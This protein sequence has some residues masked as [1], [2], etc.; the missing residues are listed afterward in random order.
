MPT[1]RAFLIP[2]VG[3]LLASGIA[4]VDSRPTWDDT[5]VTAGALFVVAALLGAVQPRGFWFTGLVVGIPVLVAN[6]VLHSNYGAAIAVIIGV[7]GAGVGALIGKG[8]GRGGEGR[9]GA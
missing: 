6:V 3:F 1:N 4:Y 8:I 5:G 2:L 7:A 9:V